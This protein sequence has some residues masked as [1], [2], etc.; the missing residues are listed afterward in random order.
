MNSQ[1]DEFV[2]SL[3]ASQRNLLRVILTSVTGWQ[4]LVQSLRH[5][6]RKL[7]RTPAA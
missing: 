6:D 4:T 7:E 1:A 5:Q 2:K 3:T